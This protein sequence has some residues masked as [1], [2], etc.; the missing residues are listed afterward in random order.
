M[1]TEMSEEEINLWKMC[2]VKFN[3]ALTGISG[4]IYLKKR[5][6]AKELLSGLLKRYDEIEVEKLDERFPISVIK[7]V[8]AKLKELNL[9]DYQ[10]L[11][12]Q[13]G[14]LAKHGKKFRTRRYEMY[15]SKINE[16]ERR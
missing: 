15:R 14:V 5:K 10:Q 3:S 13:I 2:D 1:N 11:Q 8:K 6:Y 4:A 9:D 7:S 12:K 16:A